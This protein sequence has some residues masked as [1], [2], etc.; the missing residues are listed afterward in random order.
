MD[1]E[2]PQAGTLE[3]LENHNY[4]T[5]IYDYEFMNTN[6]YL[7]LLKQRHILK[8]YFLIILLAYIT[9]I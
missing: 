7:T 4:I 6:K 9:Y 8:K 2:F 3:V 5:I 1:E